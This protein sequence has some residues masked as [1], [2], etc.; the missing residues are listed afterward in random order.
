MQIPWRGQQFAR[1]ST[2]APAPI[3]V[4]ETPRCFGLVLKRG[5]VGSVADIKATEFNPF[6][7]GPLP[8]GELG[9]PPAGYDP[10]IFWQETQ[11]GIDFRAPF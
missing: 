7:P 6:L 2:H 8:G 5:L 10:A 4:L 1:V 9:R 3:A 11:L